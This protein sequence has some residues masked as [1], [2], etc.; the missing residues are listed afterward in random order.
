MTTLIVAEKPSVARDLGRVLGAT[1]RGPGCLEGNGLRITWCIGHMVELVQPA[2]YNPDWKRWQFETLPML[3]E[4]FK[5]QPRKGVKD[6]WKDL[7]Q[8]L[9]DKNISTVVNAC[10]AGRE[11]ELIFRY[12]YEATKCKAP[13][14]RLWISS[15]TDE[16]IQK[17]WAN[18]KEGAAYEALA[19]AARCRSEADWI[20]G[21][22]ATRAMTCLAR[23]GG[24]DQLLSV[25][26]VQTPTLA[27][28][29]DRDKAIADFVPEDFW[30]VDA[31]FTLKDTPETDPITWSGRW[32][33]PKSSKSASSN[34]AKNADKA[35]RLSSAATAQAIADAARDQ[36]GTLASLH[37]R[38][39][40]E[41]PPLLYDLTSLQQRANQ[42]YGL[43]A[44]E[45]LDIA[46]A[47]YERHKVLTYPRT[48]ARHLTPDQVPGLHDVLAGLSDVPPYKPFVEE[49]QAQELRISKRMVNAE[50][51]GDHHAILPTGRSPLSANLNPNEKRVFD[52]VA[53]RLLAALS[54]E[55]IFALTDCVVEVPPNL[56]PEAGGA[57]LPEDIP[58]PLSFRSK[59]RICKQIGWQAVDPPGKK[60]KDKALPLLVEGSET[61]TLDATSKKGQTQPPKHHNDATILRGME[62]AGAKLDDPELKRAM[63]SAGLGTPATR[64]AILQTLLDR[65][66]VNRKGKELHATD[67]GTALIAAIPVDELKSAQLTGRWEARLSGIAEGTESRQDFMNAVGDSIREM[68]AAIQAAEP[69]PPERKAQSNSPELGKCPLCAKPV[70][71][72]QRVYDCDTGRACSF[73]IFKSLAKRNVSKRMVKTLLAGEQT[74]TLKGFK[75]K[76]GKDF[77]AALRLDDE[78]KVK[79]VF[80][81]RKPPPP[82][83]APAEA[84]S[85]VGDPCPT[86]QQ[87][88]II[89]GRAAFGCSRWREGCG[90][91][92]AF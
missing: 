48:D 50:E 75:S 52:L 26:R 7:K 42:R 77:S 85:P 79:F 31:Q 67:R 16:A 81:D 10:D 36:T 29:V 13:I 38:I 27:M 88:Q 51:V 84:P 17:G 6:H 5:T 8:A 76:K 14:Q 86:C 83:T 11:G 63:R 68:V 59:G 12:V 3:P 80:Q 30:Q 53:R 55:A 65:R 39:K 21:L 9:T 34:D 40:K 92:L 44:K 49:I 24:G 46:Q 74:D 72:E 15:M 35:E 78:G 28:I 43:S 71:E 37:Q 73:V 41:P 32:F 58:T 56:D 70:R 57:V 69:P 20:V 19:D 1:Q 60:R 18:L 4:T 89:A 87:G 33:R 66:F 64:A 22:N 25:G 91:R 82:T 2:D 62:T 47:L 61:S 54:P 90:Y 23:K 45:T